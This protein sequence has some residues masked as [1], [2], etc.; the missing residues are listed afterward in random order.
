MSEVVITTELRDK[1]GKGAARKIRRE[2]K[3]PVV[4][5]GHGS[6]P[7][8]LSL[9]GHDLLAGGPGDVAA[10]YWALVRSGLVCPPPPPPPRA[11][12]GRDAPTSAETPV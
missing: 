6:E 11:S 9:P 12:T 10:G 2:S 7:Q 3:V 1:F 5:Y 4:L 8:H